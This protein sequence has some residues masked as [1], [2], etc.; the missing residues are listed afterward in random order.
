MSLLSHLREAPVA[1]DL[2][3]RPVTLLESDPAIEAPA[4]IFE[5]EYC[6]DDEWNILSKK[7]RPRGAETPLGPFWVKDLVTLKRNELIAAFFR[8]KVKGWSGMTREN[9]PRFCPKAL[10]NPKLVRALPEGEIQFDAEM[11]A[12]IAAMVSTDFFFGVWGG[13]TNQG[14]FAV[15]VQ[16]QKNGA[17]A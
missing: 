17:T 3:T 13:A 11:L 4:L 14:D 7:Y 16:Q 10:A 15:E 1:E 9:L 6:E 5:L 8:R 12:D 2:P